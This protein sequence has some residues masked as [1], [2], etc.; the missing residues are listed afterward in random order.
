MNIR[1]QAA[2]IRLASLLFTSPRI[3]FRRQDLT[4]F[5]LL[6]TTHSSKGS[7]CNLLGIDS[8]QDFFPQVLL[9]RATRHVKNQTGDPIFD[10]FGSLNRAPCVGPLCL[11]RL[12]VRVNVLNLTSLSH[13]EETD[14]V[15]AFQKSRILGAQLVIRSISMVEHFNTIFD[16]FLHQGSEMGQYLL[17]LLRSADLSG[18]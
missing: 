10:V 15:K 16:F 11:L 18:L 5:T 6:L 9:R 2:H 12:I 1:A 7:I 3:F 17:Q 4:D 13:S 14:V 8:L